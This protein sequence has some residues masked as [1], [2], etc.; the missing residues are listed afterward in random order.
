MKS[1]IGSRGNS[2]F[3]DAG[4]A[5]VIRATL[6]PVNYVPMTLKIETAA[7]QEHASRACDGVACLCVGMSVNLAWCAEYE[8][9]V[10]GANDAGYGSELKR[11]KIFVRVTHE[12]THYQIGP[13]GVEKLYRKERVVES[14]RV[15]GN[16]SRSLPDCLSFKL[17]FNEHY[18]CA[19]KSQVTTD[20]EIVIHVAGPSPEDKSWHE[21]S[22]TGYA[23]PTSD[24]VDGKPR[25]ISGDPKGSRTPTDTKFEPPAGAGDTTKKS[26]TIEPNPPHC[27]NWRSYLQRQ[28]GGP[29][30]RNLKEKYA[31]PG[32]WYS[33]SRKIQDEP[34]IDELVSQ[35]FA[36]GSQLGPVQF[37]PREGVMRTADRVFDRDSAHL[38]SED[39]PSNAVD[40]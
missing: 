35:G 15:N 7:Y 34:P 39:R 33:T 37:G 14:W 25:N 36:L 26:V 12:R 40:E 28:T 17:P 23:S 10:E 5:S 22:G 13:D 1:V 16:S 9:V 6:T 21:Y 2:A 18:S 32:K 3:H 24:E 4:M 29:G 31:P 30:Y 20:A 8:Y 27:R 11:G 19:L 38:L